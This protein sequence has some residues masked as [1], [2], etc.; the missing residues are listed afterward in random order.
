MADRKKNNKSDAFADTYVKKIIDR[1]Y[2]NQEAEKHEMQD[3]AKTIGYQMYDIKNSRHNVNENNLSESKVSSHQTY[4]NSSYDNTSRHKYRDNAY[5]YNNEESFADAYVKNMINVGRENQEAEKREM[6]DKAKTIGHQMYGVKD[7]KID[8]ETSGGNHNNDRQKD[9]HDSSS[10]RYGVQRNAFD[11]RRENIE[12]VVRDNNSSQRQHHYNNT[13]PKSYTGIHTDEMINKKR[14]NDEEHVIECASTISFGDEYIRTIFQKAR[15]S[16]ET[17]KEEL[18][19]RT[20]NLN[21]HKINRTATARKAEQARRKRK[22]AFENGR[23]TNETRDNN[24]PGDDN[25]NGDDDGN[26]NKKK[27][28]DSNVNNKNDKDNGNNIPDENDKE[29]DIDDT[30]EDEIVRSRDNF[31]KYKNDVKEANEKENSKLLADFLLQQLRQSVNQ[32]DAGRGYEDYK[33]VYTAIKNPISDVV[34]SITAVGTLRNARVDFSVLNKELKNAGQS[35]IVIH[36]TI[37]TNSFRYN[38]DALAHKLGY[39]KFQYGTDINKLIK[40]DSITAVRKDGSKVTLKLNELKVK[41][42]DYMDCTGKEYVK[43]YMDSRYSSLNT[44]VSNERKVTQLINSNTKYT[45]MNLNAMTGRQI[46]K[47][48]ALYQKDEGKFANFKLTKEDIRVITQIADIKEYSRVAKMSMSSRDKDKNFTKKHLKKQV[49]NTDVVE[50]YDKTKFA[51]KGVV[52]TITAP[53]RMATYVSKSRQ[54]H[55]EARYKRRNVRAAKKPT[56]RNMK[57]ASRATAKYERLYGKNGKVTLRNERKKRIKERLNVKKRVTDKARGVKS[58]ARTKAKEIVQKLLKRTADLLIKMLGPLCGGAVATVLPLIAVIACLVVILSAIGGNSETY[59]TEIKNKN[60]QISQSVEDNVYTILKEEA[61]EGTF[62]EDEIEIAG[63]MGSIKAISNYNA[64]YNTDYN[65]NSYN[66]IAL[67]NKNNNNEITKWAVGNNYAE[68][69]KIIDADTII[70]NDSISEDLQDKILDGSATV[71]EVKDAVMGNVN[72]DGMLKTQLKRLM[73]DLPANY[74]GGYDID[75]GENESARAVQWF[76]DYYGGTDLVFNNELIEQAKEYAKEIYKSHA[77]KSVTEFDGEV[78]PGKLFAEDSWLNDYASAIGDQFGWRQ[79][80]DGSAD[81]FHWGIDFS[82]CSAM[83][84]LHT[85]VDGTVTEVSFSTSWGIHVMIQNGDY[86]LVFAHLKY[87]EADGDLQDG[88]V[89]DFTHVK[90]KEGDV[91]HAND[92]IGYSGGNDGYPYYS[93]F[94]LGAHLHFAMMDETGQ[95]IDPAGFLGLPPR[96][97]KYT[98]PE[99][100]PYIGESAGAEDGGDEEDYESV[101]DYSGDEEE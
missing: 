27:P 91:V 52:N 58:A 3:K 24:S 14:N 78:F 64:L 84:E 20:K 93:G 28:K 77:K 66:G 38:M 34:T 61:P 51:I 17:E 94:S 99:H 46:R 70:E 33:K 63:L 32:T 88:D 4:N 96:D 13:N 7:Y 18:E 101:E 37:R 100:D 95:K 15:K 87:D 55:I 73:Y 82:Y 31:K 30:S 44:A 98:D 25:G 83:T 45:S 42:D 89:V 43:A 76:F 40:N 39:E 6:Q 60:N 62:I 50:G 97:S 48:L 11:E 21:T 2:K 80:D 75:D 81:N 79:M 85:P 92:V 71:D 1:G 35:S 74:K 54:H 22:K 8:N 67:W 86:T 72:Y 41:P 59:A 56:Q 10:K 68:P 12:D 57:R 53:A 36:P 49:Q 65:D 5:Q 29:V 47:E 69:F 90:V 26:N 16:A 9:M 23:N 19:N